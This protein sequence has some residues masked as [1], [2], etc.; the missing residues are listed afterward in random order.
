MR[1]TQRPLT[2]RSVRGSSGSVLALDVKP[3]STDARGYPTLPEPC[4]CDEP[5][6]DPDSGSCLK[7]GRW[8][9]G[10]AGREHDDGRLVVSVER[11]LVI[12][13]LVV[14]FLVLLSY[15]A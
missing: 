3:R 10:L 7:C 1:L 15:V 9:G 2:G 8:A 13:I 14:L 6:P 11:V 12:A 4:A 5:I